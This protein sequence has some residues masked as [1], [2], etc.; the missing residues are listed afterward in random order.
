MW[1]SYAAAIAAIKDQTENSNLNP[2][3][4]DDPNDAYCGRYNSIYTNKHSQLQSIVP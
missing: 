4:E 3:H 2:R 1:I